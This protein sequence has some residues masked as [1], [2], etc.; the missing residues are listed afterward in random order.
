PNESLEKLVT[1]G[2]LKHEPPGQ[3]E[4]SGLLRTAG[5]RLED[6][7]KATNAPESR[8]DLAYNAAH[9]FA[10]AALRLHG[11]R[12]DKR[13]IVFQ[14]LPHTL[15]VDTPTWRLLDRCH[16]E[17][18]AT[19]YEGVGSVDEKLLDGLIEAAIELRHRVRALAG[20]HGY[21]EG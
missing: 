13:F 4:V 21:P 2:L 6:A 15:G 14:V 18:N 20:A 19:E 9:A 3:E 11:Y 17:R 8:F 7:R 10:L 12:A 1:T 5:V 16:R